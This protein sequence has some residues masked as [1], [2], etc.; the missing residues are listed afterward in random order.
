MNKEKFNH[1]IDKIYQAVRKTYGYDDFS[2]EL[3]DLIYEMAEVLEDKF[4]D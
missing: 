1:C 2:D 4:E 3:I